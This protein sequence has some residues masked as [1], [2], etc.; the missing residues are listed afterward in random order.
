MPCP[1]GQ[2]MDGSRKPKPEIRDSNETRIPKCEVR[3]FLLNVCGAPHFFSL[4][5]ERVSHF[6]LL[7]DFGDSD[8][9]F[10]SNP[11]QRAPSISLNK[12]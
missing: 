2:Y 4:H 1:A 7:S 6:G 3:A 8:F 5:R 9:G 10:N 11:N 12:S